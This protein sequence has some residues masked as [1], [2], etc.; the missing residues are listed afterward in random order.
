MAKRYGGLCPR[1]SDVRLIQ[2]LSAATSCIKLDTF[3]S[4][5]G[6]TRTYVRSLGSACSTTE[7]RPLDICD[8]I[9]LI[10]RLYRG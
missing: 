5:P 4:V 10:G 1:K 6:G 8:R 2:G 9:S 7:L 3:D